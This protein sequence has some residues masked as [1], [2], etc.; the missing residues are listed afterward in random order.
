MSYSISLLHALISSA[1]FVVAIVKTPEVFQDFHAKNLFVEL[2]CCFSI[3]YFIFDTYDM[4]CNNPNT[5]IE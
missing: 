5:G 4:I 1:L 2:A 3:G